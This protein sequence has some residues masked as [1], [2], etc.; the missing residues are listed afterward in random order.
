MQ[1]ISYLIHLTAT[2]PLYTL[3]SMLLSAWLTPPLSLHND[4]LFDKDNQRSTA[5]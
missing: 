3:I 5:L 2:Y 1:H 4:R